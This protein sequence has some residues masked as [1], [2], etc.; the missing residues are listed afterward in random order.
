MTYP[1]DGV[2]LYPPPREMNQR[3]AEGSRAESTVT[4]WIVIAIV[5]VAVIYRENAMAGFGKYVRPY[6]SLI[7]LQMILAPATFSFGVL[8]YWIRCR[9]RG[10]YGIA[11]CVV[12]VVGA[13]L[14]ANQIFA[15]SDDPVLKASL[16]M[17][18]WVASLYVIVRGLDNCYERLKTSRD[19]CYSKGLVPSGLVIWWDRFFFG[20]I[21]KIAPSIWP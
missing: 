1:T 2:I 6:I 9:S 7:G 14:V 11:E 15:S 21:S 17:F 20:R 5:A 4:T 19:I 8:L 18:S 16:T 12:G 10:I 13:L 3:E